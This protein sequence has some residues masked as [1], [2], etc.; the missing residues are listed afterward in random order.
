[1]FGTFDCCTSLTTAPVIPSS[2]K[3]MLYTFSKCTKLTGN[4]II[5]ASPTY[6]DYCFE[7]AATADNANLVVSGSSTVLDEIIATKSTN[8]HITKAK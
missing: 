3:N 1:M 6:Y 2:V 4:L 5:N 7:N 8:S